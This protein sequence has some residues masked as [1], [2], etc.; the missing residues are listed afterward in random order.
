LVESAR[1]MRSLLGLACVAV[2]VFPAGAG[3]D[4]PEKG[5]AA[6]LSTAQAESLVREVSAAVEQFRGLRFKTPVAVEVVD[7]ATARKEFVHPEQY[8]VGHRTSGPRLS[9]PDL[10]STLGPGGSRVVTG[11]IGELGLTMLTGMPLRSESYEAL[12]PTRW[13]TPGATGTAGD[14]YQHY[15]AGDRKVTVLL[16]RWESLRDADEFERN[17]RGPAKVPYRLGANILVLMGDLG[18]NRDAVAIEAVG[19]L[20]Y[21]VGR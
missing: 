13:T 16:T 9:L 12:L 19:D 18:S 15:V 20:P 21:W 17:L 11:S 6:R 14:V 7:A 8:W 5:G 2:L 10:S 1:T 4:E 3:A